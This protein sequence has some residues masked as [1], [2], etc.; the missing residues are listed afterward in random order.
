MK[1]GIIGTRKRNTR[2]DFELVKITFFENYKEGDWIVSGHCPIGGDAFAERIAFDHGIPILLFPPKKTTRK[3]FFARN[4]LIAQ[5]SDIIIA[6][7]VNPEQSLR[8]ILQRKS[9]GSENTLKHFQEYLSDRF[10]MMDDFGMTKLLE[11]RI[12][13]V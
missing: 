3:E 10:R 9:G 7:L 1:I 4:K 11:E 8:D 2:T 12:K 5:N 13:I 6:C